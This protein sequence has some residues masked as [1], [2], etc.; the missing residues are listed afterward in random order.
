[1]SELRKGEALLLVGIAKGGSIFRSDHPGD[2]ESPHAATYSEWGSHTQC[3]YDGGRVWE[4]TK[5]FVKCV[6]HAPSAHASDS[7]TLFAGVGPAGLFR[8]DD[9]GLTWTAVE[10]L[11][12]HESRGRCNPGKAALILHSVVPGPHDKMKMHVAFSVAGVFYTEDGG[13][14]WQ[15]RNRG[16]RADFLPDKHP[17]LGQCV[18]KLLPAADGKRLYRQNHCG[19]YRSDS[20]AERSMGISK[21]L[22][23]RFGFCMGTHPKETTTIWMVPITSSE[24]RVVPDGKLTVF[25]SRDA[26]G[27]W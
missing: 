6:W 2:C 11:N 16:T 19:V 9:G 10:L 20:S 12:R 5:P 7:D 3:S 25:R 22:T 18:H 17:D 26:G 8:S 1:M 21:G 4:R 14:S 23:S 15:P 24:F 13:R 27:S